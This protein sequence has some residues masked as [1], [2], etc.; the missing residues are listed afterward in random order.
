MEQVKHHFGWGIVL[1]VL[2]GIFLVGNLSSAGMDLLW[3]AFPLAVGLAFWIGYFLD[4][5]NYGLVMPGT[6][7]I[8]I[9]LLFFYCNF[10]GWGKME[11]LWPIFILTPAAGF[12]ALYFLGP[13]EAGLLIPAGILSVV[14]IIFLFFSAGFGDW[15]PVFLI[16]AGILM[17]LFSGRKSK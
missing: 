3:P 5:K 11:T 8:F 10:T 14:G 16:A 7:L 15:W 12:I 1:I 4:R 13:R 2:G 17:I 9:S 6:I